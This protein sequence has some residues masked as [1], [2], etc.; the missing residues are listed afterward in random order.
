VLLLQSS[1]S[2]L[3]VYVYQGMAQH[4][5][6]AAQHCQQ[7]GA[8]SNLTATVCLRA[9]RLAE[10]GRN[11]WQCPSDQASRA[12]KAARPKQGCLGRQ[13]PACVWQ[14]ELVL[15]RVLSCLVKEGS[16]KCSSVRTWPHWRNRQLHG[17]DTHRDR[18]TGALKASLVRC[19]CTITEQG[20]PS[21]S[22]GEWQPSRGLDSHT[23]EHQHKL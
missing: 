4:L 15:K 17:Q 5:H 23:R 21:G 6:T 9:A 20:L 14:P 7:F 19:R 3:T 11:A 1:A 10:A 22:G 2:I 12:G 18:L 8:W 13:V 16:T